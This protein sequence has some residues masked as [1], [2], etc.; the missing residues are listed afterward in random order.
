MLQL[1]R[2]SNCIL[3][4]ATMTFKMAVLFAI[5]FLFFGFFASVVGRRPKPVVAA[6]TDYE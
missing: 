1:S 3:T 4:G 6:I 2:T 5:S